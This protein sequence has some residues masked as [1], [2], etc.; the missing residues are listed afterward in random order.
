[1]RKFL[2][3]FVLV[4]AALFLNLAIANGQSLQMGISVDIVP[5]G[6]DFNGTDIVVFGSIEDVD[7][8]QLLQNEY[9]VIITVRGADEDVA[10]NCQANNC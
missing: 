6:S 5:V 8:A 4:V 7:T 9:F 10:N 2:L 3:S 1:M